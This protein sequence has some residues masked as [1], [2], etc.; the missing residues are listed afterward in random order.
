M[1]DDVI[2]AALRS[3][4]KR[5]GLSL[6]QVARRAG[7]SAATV[8]RYENGWDR[9]EVYTLRKLAAALG[10]R[11]ETRLC[12]VRQ[13]ARRK[14]AAKAVAARL[15]RLF[16]DH[17]LQATDLDA[18][19]KWVTERVLEYGGLEDIRALIG[20]MGHP[21]FLD[22]VRQANWSSPRTRA[23]WTAILELENLPCTKERFRD[24]AANCWTD[25]RR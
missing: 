20:F 9:F 17:P 10:C 15:K 4:R 7:T 5:A 12:P 21:R 11:L 19:P 13:P 1:N 14:P 25:W 2:S 6:T 24:Q 16:W 3:R 8:S 23:F 22:Q 18:C